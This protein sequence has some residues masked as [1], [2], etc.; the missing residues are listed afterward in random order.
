MGYE[1]Q[2]PT[3]PQSHFKTEAEAAHRAEHDRLMALIRNVVRAPRVGFLAADKKSR[4]FMFVCSSQDGGPGGYEVYFVTERGHDG[5]E[6]MPL[7]E[8]VPLPPATRRRRYNF[9][10]VT[11]FVICHAMRRYFDPF[12]PRPVIYFGQ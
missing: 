2:R 11:S 5:K 3:H 6:W 4:T 8:S 10:D 1:H 9:R 7:V 12:G